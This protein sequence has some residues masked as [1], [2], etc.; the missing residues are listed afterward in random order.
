MNR[1]RHYLLL[2]LVS[3]A[4]LISGCDTVPQAN[5]PAATPAAPGTPPARGS[6]HTPTPGT[7]VT[8][9]A[10][11]VLSVDQVAL[12]DGIELYNKGQ[13]NDAIKRLSGPEITSGPVTNQVAALKYMAF[14]YCVT[15]RTTLCRQ[16]FEK[17]FKL[18]PNFDLAPGEH[19][20]PLW[21]KVFSRAKPAAVKPK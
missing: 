11:P 4:A 15:N 18:D 20:H 9:P 2:A 1:S 8:P 12:N 3:G 21:G 6:T 19:G 14:S 13:F 7:T 16:Q 17:A 5:A 10:P